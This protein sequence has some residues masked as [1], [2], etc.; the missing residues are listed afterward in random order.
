MIKK[1]G[2]THTQF[3]P[4][5]SGDDA[6]LMI[7]KAIKMG[8]G[9][10]SITEHAP[11]PPAFTNQYDGQPDGLN[12][13][14][15]TTNQVLPYLEFAEKMKA[16]YANQIKI[17]VGF[18]VDYLPGFE[19]WTTAFLNE[20]GNRTQ[21]NVLS[22]HFMPGKGHKFWCVDD[23]ITDFAQG[24]ETM[25]K[26][27]Q[28]L[29]TNFL[30]LELRAVQADLGN[31]KPRRIGHLTLIRKFQDYFNLPREFS[32]DNQ[33]LVEQ[34]LSGIKHRNYQLDLNTAGLYKEFCNEIYPSRS[35]V[36]RAREMA[37][38]LV[39]G[40]DA[41]SI[42]EVGHGYHEVAEFLD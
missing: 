13:A 8:F 10:Y 36:K 33:R 11:L 20:Y 25:L 2:H 42:K 22:V 30:K 39:F 40:S 31:Y 26:Q 28:T 41:H 21:D 23:T 5:G 24:F 32:Q 35:I 7:Q 29:F 37:I 1:D 14:S 15:L 34:I 3:C 17:N 9:E 27:P 38:P 12:L 19:D 16:R 18:E 6:E 4:H